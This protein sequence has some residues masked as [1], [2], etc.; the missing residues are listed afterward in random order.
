MK[1]INY[2]YR[3]IVTYIAYALFGIG[4]VGLSFVI[5]PLILVFVKNPISKKK[6]IR[7]SIHYA[8]KLFISFLNTTRIARV[9]VINAHKIKEDNGCIIIANHPTLIDV[10][11][12]IAV[13]KNSTCIVKHTLL[14][15]WFIKKIVIAAQYIPNDSSELLI[16]KVVE[17]FLNNDNLIIFPEGTR[18][19]FNK[20]PVFQR[21]A[22][23][24]ALQT[25]ASVR[26]T[27]IYCNVN[28]LN[29]ETPWY[30]IPEEKIELHITIKE[31]ISSSSYDFSR[32]RSLE[33][34]KL[35]KYFKESILH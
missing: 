19:T 25:R 17:S 30:V 5:F 32:E 34:R 9:V 22:S 26:S 8:F 12:L 11:A 33:A 18:T 20:E 35:T 15:N 10:V 23:H 21:G 13:Y 3:A 29:K 14:K 6:A 2:I 1:S 4:A 24:L 27:H 31:K 28:A 7:G 16:S